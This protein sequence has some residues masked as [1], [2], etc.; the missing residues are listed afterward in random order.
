MTDNPRDL[1][2]WIQRVELKYVMNDREIPATHCNIL[3]NK[4]HNIIPLL[5]SNH[6]TKYNSIINDDLVPNLELKLYKIGEEKNRFM[7]FD[8]VKN[9]IHE[10]LL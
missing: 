4:L 8:F 6:I 7:L 1:W 3:L 2:H 9:L 10:C 5:K